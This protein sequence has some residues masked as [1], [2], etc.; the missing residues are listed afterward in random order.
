MWVPCQSTVALSELMIVTLHRRSTSRTK[1][2]FPFAPRRRFCPDQ[3][4]SAA[5]SR[6][7]FI[8]FNAPPSRPFG[9]IFKG[10][11]NDSRSSSLR[12]IRDIDGTRKVQQFSP[13]L[14]VSRAKT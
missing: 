12:F 10:M 9:H 14:W 11:I 5:D 13:P 1:H 8:V 7:Q 6:K 2:Q 4:K 3:S